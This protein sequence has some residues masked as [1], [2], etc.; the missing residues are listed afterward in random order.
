MAGLLY[1][2]DMDEVRARLKTWWEGGDI[3]RPAMS[4]TVPPQRT[5]R[6]HSR[7][8]RTGRM[9]NGLLHQ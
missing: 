9:G 6:T 7:H 1:R 3:G 2:E 5:Y 8:A 4:L